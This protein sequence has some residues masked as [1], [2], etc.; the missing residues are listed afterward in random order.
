MITADQA[1]K[2]T[3]DTMKP[4]KESLQSLSEKIRYQAGKGNNF[5]EYRG[6]P[7]DGSWYSD[8]KKL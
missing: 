8:E 6:Y 4:Y 1:S 7:V 2:I 3:E 5:L